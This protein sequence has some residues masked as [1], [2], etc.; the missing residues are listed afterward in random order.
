M[1][2]QDILQGLKLA[3]EKGESLEQAMMSFYLAG[4]LKKDIEEAAREVNGMN[5]TPVQTTTKSVTETKSPT[6]NKKEKKSL[7]GFLTRKKNEDKSTK[8]ILVTPSPQKVSSYGDEK[9]KSLKKKRLLILIV[10][11]LI[12][13]TLLGI[14]SIVFFGGMPF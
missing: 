12:I 14:L 6:N 11:I 7:F 5:L 4:Y 8:K 3:L 13:L 9:K 10:F 1:V 2:K